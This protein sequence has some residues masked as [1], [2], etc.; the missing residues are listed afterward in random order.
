M[1]AVRDEAVPTV[2][3][4]AVLSDGGRVVLLVPVLTVLSGAVQGQV[5]H[6]KASDRT[7]DTGQGR[8]GYSSVGQW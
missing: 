6:G 4:G 7:L 1:L 5:G 2:L 8:I 3:E